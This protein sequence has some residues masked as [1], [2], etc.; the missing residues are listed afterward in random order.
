MSKLG[1][2]MKKKK[3]PNWKTIVDPYIMLTCSNK[4]VSIPDVDNYPYEHVLIYKIRGIST[5]M[6]SLNNATALC[7]EHTLRTILGIDENGVGKSIEIEVKKLENGLAAIGYEV[8]NENNHAPQSL[9]IKLVDADHFVEEIDK[10]INQLKKLLHDSSTIATS[11]A[12]EFFESTQ[13]KKFNEF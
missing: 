1:L 6:S 12:K 8:D 3:A 2:N 11:D 13:V 10:L 7:N 5:C 9:F 4:L